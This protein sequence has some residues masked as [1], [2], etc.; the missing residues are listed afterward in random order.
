[1]QLHSQSHGSPVA[2]FGAAALSIIIS[3]LVLIPGCGGGGGSGDAGSTGGALSFRVRW[4]PD[5]ASRAVGGAAAFDDV[6][7]SVRSVRIDY[8]SGPE[9]DFDLSCCVRVAR[10]QRSLLLTGIP[11]G[12]GSVQLTGY[13]TAEVPVPA[14]ISADNPPVCT[15]QLRDENGDAGAE[16][17]SACQAGLFETPSFEGDV[18]DVVFT[19]GVVDEHDVDMMAV[20][21]LFNRDPDAGDSHPSTESIHATLAHAGKDTNYDCEDIEVDFENGDALDF[22]S[23]IEHCSDRAGEGPPRCSTGDNLDVRGCIIEAHHPPGDATINIKGKTTLDDPVDFSYSFRIQETTVR[24]RLVWRLADAVDVGSL[25]WVTDYSNAPGQ[26]LGS[27]DIPNNGTLQ[28]ASLVDEALAS[29]CDDDGAGDCVGSMD[30]ETLAIALAATPGFAGPVD[31]IECTML[32]TMDPIA[33]D[34][35]ITIVEATDPTATAIVPPPGVE[36]RVDSCVPVTGAQ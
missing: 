29:F 27:G 34:F 13:A 19:P 24:C 14:R 6:P 36:I 21:F 5:T 3:I 8:V 7:P 26:I 2:L 12:E 15:V 33:G 31:L 11:K 18:V 25:Q 4:D 32:A 23:T 20:P 28:C 9:A 16:V 30:E 35:V 10:G 1:M 17:G 22:T